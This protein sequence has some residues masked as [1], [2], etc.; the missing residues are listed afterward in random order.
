[1]KALSH[2]R[3][4]LVPI[5]VADEEGLF[6]NSLVTVERMRRTGAAA[7]DPDRRALEVFIAAR[8]PPLARRSELDGA[9]RPF[10][11][12]AEEIARRYPS[13]S[14]AQVVAAARQM[15]P[16][17]L[18]RLSRGS[19]ADELPGL[20]LPG[21]LIALAYLG[22]LSLV[23]AFIFRGGL[24][25]RLFQT[26]VVD[27]TGTEVSRWRALLRAGIAWS[28]VLAFQFLPQPALLVF[29][30]YPWSP[31]QW[32]GRSSPLMALGTCWS[33]VV[34]ERGWHDW[35]GRTWLVPR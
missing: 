4:G 8:F 11:P 16:A 28:P 31:G 25:L 2:G 30:T 35:I 6:L 19:L 33:I 13:P 3:A 9:L 17:Q 34:P 23:L 10:R 1:M 7:S 27:T 32:L 20:V 14:D 24:I 18:D 26:A 15:G 29:A 12:L 21:V 5:I 22:Y